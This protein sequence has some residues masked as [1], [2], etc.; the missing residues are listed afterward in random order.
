MSN[1]LTNYCLK[2]HNTFGISAKAKYF[3]SFDS[4]DKLIALLKDNICKTAPIFIL[5]GGSNILLC[6][7]YKGLV[8]HID[9]KGITD[10]ENNDL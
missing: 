6:D 7:D 5:G 1:I 3:S 10:L 8:V 2:N 9:L 4:E